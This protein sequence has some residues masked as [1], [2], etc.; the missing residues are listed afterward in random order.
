MKLQTLSGSTAENST[1]RIN[2]SRSRES[3]EALGGERREIVMFTQNFRDLAAPSKKIRVDPE[4]LR[5]RNMDLVGELWENV[6]QAAVE[7]ARSKAVTE[8]SANAKPK[9]VASR[10]ECAN[11]LWSVH[12]V[13][14]GASKVEDGVSSAIMAVSGEVIDAT[15]QKVS[16]I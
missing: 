12:S 9:L 11:S 7:S 5:K 15:K 1:L 13:A 16:I 10:M 6:L 3:F 2:V 4:A 8:V 14:K